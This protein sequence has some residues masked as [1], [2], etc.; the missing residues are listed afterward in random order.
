[1]WKLRYPSSAQSLRKGIRCMILI[2]RKIAKATEVSMSKDVS[3]VGRQRKQTKRSALHW[4]WMGV[5]TSWVFSAATVNEFWNASKYDIFPRRTRQSSRDF[6]SN[7]NHSQYGLNTDDACALP[8][9]MSVAPLS[10]IVVGCLKAKFVWVLSVVIGTLWVSCS[11]RATNSWRLNI[12]RVDATLASPRITPVTFIMMIWCCS[13]VLKSDMNPEKVNLTSVSLQYR[14]SI[15]EDVHKVD[16]QN[17]ERWKSSQRRSQHKLGKRT[18]YRGRLA[19]LISSDLRWL[20][21]K[22]VR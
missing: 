12:A 1:M 10:M 8:I 3:N 16:G 20:Q 14:A 11:P 15:P 17:E 4:S 2:L 21:N 7:R 13:G 6:N 5:S 22:S 9:S 19:S 18:Y